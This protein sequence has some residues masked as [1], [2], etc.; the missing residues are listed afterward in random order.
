M[1][2]N[3]FFRRIRKIMTTAKVLNKT[4][5]TCRV[6]NNAKTRL[7]LVFLAVALVAVTLSAAAYAAS[8]PRPKPTPPP[9]PAENVEKPPMPPTDIT[10][11]EAERYKCST[12]TSAR[13]RIRCRINL[14]EENELNYLPEECRALNGSARGN[15]VSNYNLV[16][17]CW[18]FARDEQR[19]GCAKREFGLNGTVA[20]QKAICE[21]LTGTERSN[22][23]LQ[24]R[25]KVDTV[26][27]FRMYNLE[28]KAQRLKARGVSE[29]LVVDFVTLI[30]Q[31]KQEYNNAK[32]GE[33]KKAI[34]REVKELWQSFITNAK[35]QVKA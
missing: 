32:T 2:T 29:E 17:K 33:E 1:L 5:L 30:E 23:I 14:Q 26:V 10:A 25:D 13:E 18:D 6:M 15:C 20:S 28:E 27:K 8:G 7:L 22:C 4:A 12:I 34:V 3:A 35:R 9:P 19:I 21:G 16:Q 24:L 11:A 31:K